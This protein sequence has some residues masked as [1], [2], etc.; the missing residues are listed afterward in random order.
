MLASKMKV[1]TLVSKEVTSKNCSVFGDDYSDITGKVICN[2]SRQGDQVVVIEWD[3]K[4]FPISLEN[5]NDLNV[6]V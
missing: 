5:V 3:T 6:I 4:D 1:G 2:N